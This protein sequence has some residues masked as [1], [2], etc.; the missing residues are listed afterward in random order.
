MAAAAS[1]QFYYT[2]V[3]L[4]KQSDDFALNTF[5]KKYRHVLQKTMPDAQWIE[6]GNKSEV[7]KNNNLLTLCPHIIHNN[8]T[9]VGG[10]AKKWLETHLSEPKLVPRPAHLVVHQHSN[11]LHNPPRK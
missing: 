4:L 9:M 10:V 3:Q 6:V 1:T 11:H 2:N 5:M 8:V 7:S